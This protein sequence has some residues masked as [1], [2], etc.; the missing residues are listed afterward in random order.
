MADEL[1]VIITADA[2]GVGP[3]VAQATAAVESSADQIAAAQA[4][5]TAATKAL[6]EAQVQLGAA[7]EGGNAQAAAIIQQYAQASTMATAAVQQLTASEEANTAATLSNAAAQ[8]VDTVATYS[9][10]EAME[11]AKVSMGAMTGS[12]YM[13]ETGL[14]KVAA[15]SSV[16]GPMLAAMVPVAIFA[17]GV[18]LLYDLGE[19]L[20]KAFDMGG[21]GA[22]EFEQ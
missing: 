6:T 11:A 14:A 19:A 9:H 22:R 18:F 3:A 7:A 4:K 13:M 15:G 21:E 10:S 2:S 1:R 8:R 20:Y 5:A 12:A 17:A 16:V